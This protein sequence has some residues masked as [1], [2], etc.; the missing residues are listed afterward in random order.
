MKGSERGCFL[1]TYKELNERVGRPVESAFVLCKG[2][3]S[4]FL[5]APHAFEHIRDGQ[6]KT[7]EP[8]SGVLAIMLGEELGCSYA[9]TSS[10]GNDPNWDHRSEYRDAVHDAIRS[11]GCKYLL[12]LH[13]L[14]P[15]RDVDIDI[16]TA[17]GN[18]LV[19]QDW[20]TALMVE[21]FVLQGFGKVF[22]DEPFAA[23]KP[24]TVAASTA[25]TCGIPA[26]QVEI[27]S[28]YLTQGYE[29]FAPWR[30]YDALAHIVQ[31]LEERAV[32]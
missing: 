16:G 7:A 5:S 12:D 26:V 30:V 10:R 6:A 3:G 28:R 18:N 27:N 17:D 24:Q 8:G 25:L 13:Q 29:G 19:G 23:R 2:N 22:V 21:E 1:A 15:V 11:C 20:M 31:S 32:R 9:Y 14:S 4:V